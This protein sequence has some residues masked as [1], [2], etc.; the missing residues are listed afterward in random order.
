[1]YL[2]SRA[3]FDVNLSQMSLFQHII[4][5]PCIGSIRH[6]PLSLMPMYG[7]LFFNA[8]YDLAV[9]TCSY[10]ILTQNDVVNLYN[11]WF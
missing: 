6:E 5:F 9:C 8:V 10:I 3:G 11:I 7:I 2:Q 1:M 4:F